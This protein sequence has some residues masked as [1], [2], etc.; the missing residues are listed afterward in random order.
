MQ[1]VNIGHFFELLYLLVLKELKIRYKNSFFGY[2]WAILNPFAFA[3][4]YYIAFKLVMRVE[5]S[6]YSNFLISGM[7]PWIWFVNGLVKATASF[8]SNP[9]LVKKVKIN[10]MIL[11]MSNV[12]YEMVHF[13]FSLPII[14]FFIVFIGGGD[15]HLSWFWQIPLLILQQFI[16]IYSISIIL[17]ITN[18]FIHDIEYITGIF[19]SLLFFLTPVVYSEDLIPKEYIFLSKLNP[20]FHLIVNWRGIFLNGYF[21]F[22]SYFY[23]SIIMV[24]ICIFS[25]AIYQTKVDKLGELL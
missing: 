11:P 13:L 10:R 21:N 7:F 18:V 22:D 6:N 14:I 19:V 23:L 1:I 25:Y 4:V 24:L 15:V 8:R 3:L 2:L 20:L 16:F 12:T 17:A 9:S 5:I